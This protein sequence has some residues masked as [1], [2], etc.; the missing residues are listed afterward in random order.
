M[1]NV[2][3]IRLWNV[4]VKAICLFQFASFQV[5]FRSYGGAICAYKMFLS[6]H[7][8]QVINNTR[9]KSVYIYWIMLKQYCHEH[10]YTTLYSVNSNSSLTRILTNEQT[11]E[12]QYCD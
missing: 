12:H 11:N 3:Q 2:P 6:P 1:R 4:D 5:W 7:L 8:L 10:T 9:I